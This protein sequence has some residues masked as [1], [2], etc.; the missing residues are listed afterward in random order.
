MRVRG[1]VVGLAEWGC[2][3]ELRGWRQLRAFLARSDRGSAVE[4]PPAHDASTAKAASR[5][6]NTNLT[7]IPNSP[8]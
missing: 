5:D 7:T 6:D 8:F 1:S 4:P 2:R 3:L